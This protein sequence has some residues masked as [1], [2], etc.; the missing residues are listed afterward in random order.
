VLLVVHVQLLLHGELQVQLSVLAHY[1][2]I[3]DDHYLPLDVDEH[4]SHLNFPQYG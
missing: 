3:R 2:D 1:H 4:L